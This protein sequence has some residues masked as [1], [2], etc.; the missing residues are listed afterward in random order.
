M[1]H[2]ERWR[3]E[4]KGAAQRVSR[5]QR[6]VACREGATWSH[7]A[8]HGEIVLALSAAWREIACAPH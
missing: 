2:G 7:R 3:L 1:L 4:G 6:L 8:P 5:V